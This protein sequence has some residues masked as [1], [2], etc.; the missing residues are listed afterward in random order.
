MYR[1]IPKEEFF[2]ALQNLRK[3]KEIVN[4]KSDLGNS[5]VIVNKTDYLDKM[6]K[7][8]NDTREFEEINLKNFEF[9]CQPRKT[10]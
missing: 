3:N 7:L 1:N 5:F 2:L 6:E 10:C 4:Q 9:C 8:R